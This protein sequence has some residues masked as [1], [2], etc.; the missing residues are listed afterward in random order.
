MKPLNADA[1]K[2]RRRSRTASE[3]NEKKKKIVETALNLLFEEQGGELPSVD[4]IAKSS[5][6][7][8]GTIYLYFK[9]KEEIF[10]YALDVYF[11]NWFEEI[12]HELRDTGVREAKDFAVCFSRP[13]LENEQFLKLA[14]MKRMVFQRGLSEDLIRDHKNMI[15]DGVKS[16]AGEISKISGR[17]MVKCEKLIMRCYAVVLGCHYTS[18]PPRG[19]LTILSAEE[20]SVLVLNLEEDIHYILKCL[21]TNF[22]QEN[23]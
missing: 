15:I 5:S 7:A 16:V 4:R 1:S 19:D 12:C 6:V 17:D 13:V 2:V 14:S 8:K 18:Y 21:W 3:K 22:L 20:R 10:L 9:T 11:K 23:S